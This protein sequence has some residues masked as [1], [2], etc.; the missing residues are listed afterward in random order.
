MRPPFALPRR[1]PAARQPGRHYYAAALVAL[2]H[3]EWHIVHGYVTEG[4]VR[5][6]HAW[7][8]RVVGPGRGWVYDAED[9][10]AL[11]PEAYALRRGAIELGRW[12][13]REAQTMCLRHGS[14]GPWPPAPTS[15]DSRSASE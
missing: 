3:D 10:R 12:P 2:A 14:W 7:N 8:V 6:P 4:R 9:G 5:I 15:I 1:P 11:P 13:G